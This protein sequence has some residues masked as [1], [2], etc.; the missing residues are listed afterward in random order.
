MRDFSIF[1]FLIYIHK[2]QKSKLYR[3]EIDEFLYIINIMNQS[4]YFLTT[5]IAAGIRY[6]DTKKCA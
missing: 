2:S 6:N 3:I 1:F 4:E 5:T